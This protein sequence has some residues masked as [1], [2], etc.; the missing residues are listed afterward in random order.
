MQAL[1]VKLKTANPHLALSQAPA[2]E[3]HTGSSSFLRPTQPSHILNQPR[4]ARLIFLDC[5]ELELPEQRR[6]VRIAH[7]S[8]VPNRQEVPTEV[9]DAHPTPVVTFASRPS[10]SAAIPNLGTKKGVK[11]AW[12]GCRQHGRFLLLQNLH[13]RHPWRSSC[14][15]APMDGFT[16][17]L[18]RHTPHPKIGETAQT[19][20]CCL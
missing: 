8:T 5:R 4:L 13:S 17:F 19:G 18:V 3:R 11:Y 15:Q 6:R 2:W 12:R 7:L 16:A 20:N 10:S 14:R 9:R 1:R